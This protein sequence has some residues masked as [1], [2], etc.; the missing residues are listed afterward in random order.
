MLGTGR[1][2]QSK[3]LVVCLGQRAAATRRHEAW[4]ADLRKNHSVSVRDGRNPDALHP[5][6]M[7]M[8]GHTS[9]AYTAVRESRRAKRAT[10]MTRSSLCAL[11]LISVTCT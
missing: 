3:K 10:A 5:R 7:S 1:S 8:C 2:P 6:Q 11:V 4:I 9:D